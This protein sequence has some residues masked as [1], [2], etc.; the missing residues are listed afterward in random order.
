[1]RLEKLPTAVIPRVAPMSAPALEQFEGNL[2]APFDIPVV[3]Y[4]KSKLLT[5][6][7]L[8]VLYLG[9]SIPRKNSQF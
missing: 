6:G 3:K 5:Q 2:P 4:G 9:I 8:K 1:M 7:S